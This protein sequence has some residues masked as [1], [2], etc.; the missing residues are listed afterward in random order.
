MWS[1]GV[2]CTQCEAKTTPSTIVDVILIW[3]IYWS[4]SVA[5]ADES[6][7]RRKFWWD[8][9]AFREVEYL[10]GEDL[11]EWTNLARTLFKNYIILSVIGSSFH[12]AWLVIQSSTH[13]LQKCGIEPSDG[14]IPHFCWRIG[15]N[16]I[17]P[18]KD[19]GWWSPVSSSVT[20]STHKNNTRL[21]SRTNTDADTSRWCFCADT[22]AHTVPTKLRS[23][24][25]PRDLPSPIH[26]LWQGQQQNLQ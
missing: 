5:A 20:T 10:N 6:R 15:G 21:L 25:N 8:G 9:M 14:S 3:Y 18:I 22:L 11:R 23:D 4:G 24:N 17:L 12:Q 26:R 7:T 1:R 2:L 19:K 16:L 13:V